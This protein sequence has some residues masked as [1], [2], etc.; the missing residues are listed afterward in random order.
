MIVADKKVDRG[1]FETGTGWVLKPE[2]ACRGE[3]CV[4]LPAEAVIDE[5]VDLPLVALRLR[6]PI[7]ADGD[8]G[9]LAV[10]PAVISGGVLAT[11]E[12]PDLVLPDLAGNSFSISSLRGQKVLLVAWAPY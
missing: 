2:G 11:A 9:A 3:V 1:T 10:G 12:M 4:P 5:I 6:M 8:T 7:V